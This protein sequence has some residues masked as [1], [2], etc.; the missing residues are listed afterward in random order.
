[1]SGILIYTAS[2]DSE[3]TLGGL[4]RQGRPD[5]FPRMFKK[6]IESAMMCSNDPVCSLSMGQGRDSLNLAACYSC[7]L[8]PETS[9]EE[10]NVF[11]DRAVV[12]GTFDNNH[13]G[14][15]S[16]KVYEKN[17]WKIED[18]VNDETVSEENRSRSLIVNSGTD[19][20]EV[21]YNEIWDSLM[22]W[23][24]NEEERRKL[25]EIIDRSSE[26]ERK[27][28][29]LSGC[30]FMLSGFPEMYS[31]DLIW[32]RSKVAFFTEENECD[33][34]VARESDWKCFCSTD[35]FSVDELFER[36]KEV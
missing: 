15:Y 3:G 32:K 5:V 31:C 14:F 18:S 4:V 28:K 7:T 25:K 10:F 1:M 35:D 34:K 22:Q 20:N 17:G 36:I 13:I 11:L 9:C 21:S 23:S 27:E 8:I 16:N 12:V 29:P 6:A 30:E 26:L 19:M 33:C 24:E 2:G